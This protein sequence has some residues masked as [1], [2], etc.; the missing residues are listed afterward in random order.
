VLKNWNDC[1]N[2][3]REIALIDIAVSE[4][5]GTRKQAILNSELEYKKATA[6]SLARRE[7]LIEELEGFYRSKRK[8]VEVGGRRSIDLNFGRL[9]MR[10][11]KP[12][13]AL[14]KGWK[15]ERVLEAIKDRWARNAEML[16]VLVTTKESV[17]K[18]GLKS[19]LNEEA[20]AQV[21]LR[22]KQ[23]DEFFFETYPEKAKQAA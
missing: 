16:K 4:A 20:M 23:G 5:D 2:M 14:A 10:L 21:G 19:H 8:E 13:L 1:D 9:G 11:G 3:L 7:T 22:L 17:N 6:P 15:W 12:T 18:D